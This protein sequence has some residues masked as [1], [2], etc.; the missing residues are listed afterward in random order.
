MFFDEATVDY[1]G[2]GVEHTDADYPAPDFIIKQDSKGNWYRSDI[3]NS[4]AGLTMRYYTDYAHSK[5]LLAVAGIDATNYALNMYEAFD[6]VL[7]DEGYTT[8][9]PQG[10]EIGYENQCW[11]IGSGVSTAAKAAN[12]TK[13]AL[14]KGFR[15][16]YHCSS[17]GQM[18]TWFESYISQL[19]R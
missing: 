18:A 7:S 5:G 14:Q 9:D 11:V 15:A 17:Y 10:A 6:Y 4:W 12:Y 19:S 13:T 3:P 2:V 16:A 8:R 1:Q